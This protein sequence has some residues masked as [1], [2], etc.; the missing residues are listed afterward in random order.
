[1]SPV[2]W[3]LV[4]LSSFCCHLEQFHDAQPVTHTPV[5]MDPSPPPN[6]HPH[7]QPRQQ[8]GAFLLASSLSLCQ[9]LPRAPHS[10]LS[11]LIRLIGFNQF[12]ATNKSPGSREGDGQGRE[13]DSEGRHLLSVTC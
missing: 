11:G 7:P 2:S 8:H 12:P 9:P 10:R 6:P 4:F 13:S 5:W 1:M 3:A